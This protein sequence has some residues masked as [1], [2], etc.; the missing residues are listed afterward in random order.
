MHQCFCS[1]H[2]DTY[3]PCWAGTWLQA[4]RL[5]EL[6]DSLAVPYDADNLQ[7]Q[8]QLQEL[9]ALAFPE[10]PFSSLKHN[11]WKEMGWQVG[12]PWKHHSS[13]HTLVVLCSIIAVCTTARQ[14]GS[15]L[16]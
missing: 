12:R 11:Q 3:S 8:Q 14:L 2:S 5:E 9:W 10:L 16:Q 1:N 6:Q 15:R 13:P 4:Q 7:H